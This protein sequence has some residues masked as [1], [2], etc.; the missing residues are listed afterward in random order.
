MVNNILDSTKKGYY[1]KAKLNSSIGNDKKMWEVIIGLLK[2]KKVN[3]TLIDEFTMNG[4]VRY[5]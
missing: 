3:K 1:Y 5:T 2:T 4:E